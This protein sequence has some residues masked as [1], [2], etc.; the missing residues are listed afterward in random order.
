MPGVGKGGTSRHPVHQDH[1][2]KDK[3]GVH[4]RLSEKK[5]PLCVQEGVVVLV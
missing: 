4:I 3:R 1:W 5:N 2:V